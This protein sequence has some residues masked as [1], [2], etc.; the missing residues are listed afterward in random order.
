MKLYWIQIW[1]VSLLLTGITTTT[2]G[3]SQHDGVDSVKLQKELNSTIKTGNV[4]LKFGG[5]IKLDIIQDFNPIGQTDQF[6]ISSIPT[7]GSSG[8]NFRIHAR[9]SRVNMDLHAPVLGKDMRIFTE[10]DFFGSNNSYT[11]RLRHV[12]ANWGPVLAGQSWSTFVD[13]HAMPNTID[14]ESPNT[15]PN[16]RVA[17]LRLT[18]HTGKDKHV[19]LSFA[20]EEATHKI[21]APDSITGKENKLTP[22]FV[23]R[24][25]Y[26]KPRGHIQ[27]GASYGLIDFIPDAG[28]N[29]TANLWGLSLSG[30]MNIATKDAFMGTVVYGNG[31]NLYRSGNTTATFDLLGQLDVPAELGVMAAYEHYWS[32]HVSS[33]V[34]YG[35]GEQY[36][37]DEQITP[38]SLTHVA[39]Y[40]SANLLWWFLG[41]YGYAGIEYIY[42]SRETPSGAT[43]S[44]HRL[45]AALKFLLP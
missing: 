8:T 27:F 39:H 2:A 30:K 34:S 22:N 45:Q 33:T 44:A 29:Q 37:D 38:E 5:F 13:E 10:I 11:P 40:L 41:K 14:F 4:T 28:D 17:Q 23:G 20:I 1:S 18:T 24:V 9:Q 36:Y 25:V 16:L 32:S 12:Y 26:T 21:I 19:A 43:G 7:D 6:D 15:F 35:Y 31:V 3:W 42:G